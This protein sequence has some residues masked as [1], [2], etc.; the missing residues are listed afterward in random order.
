MANK[1]SL[2]PT[3][4]TASTGTLQIGDQWNAINII[5]H[6]QTHPLKAICELVENAIDARAQHI[7]I[8]RRRTKNEILLEIFDDGNGLLL[9]QNGQPD[10]DHI[11]TH[12]CDSMKRHLS[13]RDRVGV[14]GE[15]GIGLLSF[16]S[17]GDQLRMIAGDDEGRLHEMILRRG[18]QAY[19]VKPLRGA[20]DTGGT[21]ITVGPL[22]ESTRNIVTG[23]KLQR[24]LAAEL[25]D[26]IRSS[27]VHIHI[28]DKIS[29][30]QLVVTPREFQGDRLEEVRSIATPFGKLVVELYL[31]PTADNRPQT[32]VAICKDGTRVLSDITEL[33]QFDR[34]PWNNGRLEGI[35][36]YA[37]FNLA[38]G[39]RKGVVPDERLD[40]FIV[41]VNQIEHDVQKAIERRDAA[42]SAKANRQILR[43]VKRAF[44]TALQELP[45]D[46][47][48]FFDVPYSNRRLS[49][50]TGKT[51][52]TAKQQKTVRKKKE[53]AT[54]A[55]AAKPGQ[56]DTVLVTPRHARRQPKGDCVM[57]AKAYDGR[58]DPL[59][60][61][62]SYNWTII[63]G[64]G[65]L[66]NIDG[67][68]CTLTSRKSGRVVVQVEA[69]KGIRSA[70]DKVAVKFLEHEEDYGSARGLPSYRLQAER[71]QSWRSR[72]DVKKNE[73]TINSTHRDF[74][75]SQS[76]LAKHRRYI[77]KLYAKEVVLLNFPHESSSQAMERLIEVI[78]RTEDA[79]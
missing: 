74:V 60:G 16:W 62:V 70:T 14:H 26:R 9:N 49:G 75:A 41:A 76:T 59:T 56:L 52:K 15:F 3:N 78:V 19:S 45:E 30:K 65:R 35:L 55:V 10:F 64:D 72:Y 66:K 47:Y 51:E 38:P 32:H 57:M 7:Q 43:Q 22:L 77:G 37:P 40:A 48:L 61:K 69:S 6:S 5:A 27:G 4:S 54:V 79:L 8:I 12:V 29:R 21:Q 58:D 39:T 20:F 42:E 17:L 23:D 13:R 50:G 34:A 28:A 1:Q 63:E 24:Y 31:R 53:T 36:D 25:R 2:P 73:I 33:I 44:M 18:E 71:G 68:K 67:A 11:A 46:Q